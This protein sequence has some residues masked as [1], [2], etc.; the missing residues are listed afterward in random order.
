MIDLHV[1]SVFSD[2]SDA[3]A[4]LVRMAVESGVTGLALTDHDTMDGT[5]EFLD[6][7]RA[8]TITGLSGIELSCE[9]L[10]GGELHILGYGLNPEH[11]LVVEKMK[12]AQEKR[13]ERNHRIV[14][15]LNELGM[16]LTWEDVLVHAEKGVVGRP[17][18]ASALV[19][20]QMVTNTSQAFSLYLSKGKPAYQE[21]EYMAP[22]EGIEMIHA[23]GGVAVVAHPFLWLK[24]S[25]RLEAGLRKLKAMG[26]DGVEVRYTSHTSEQMMELLRLAGE[27]GFFPTGGSDYHGTRKPDIKVGCGFSSL[28]VPDDYLTAIFRAVHATENPFVVLGNASC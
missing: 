3:P 8:A 13:M 5:G 7:C 21:R 20:R 22:Q 26:A 1:H 14:A 11:P 6:A 28:C 25:H 24:D 12:W 15:K 18:I 23:A 16:P 9:P 2:G 4:E 27:I 10:G 17:H 19:A